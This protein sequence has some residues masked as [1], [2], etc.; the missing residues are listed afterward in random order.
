MRW[1]KRNDINSG[2]ADGAADAGTNVAETGDIASFNSDSET[3]VFLI[4][5][6]LPDQKIRQT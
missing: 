6:E 5:M 2:A 3:A 1:L 4:S